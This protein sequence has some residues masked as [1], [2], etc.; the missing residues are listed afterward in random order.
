MK[1]IFRVIL[2]LLIVQASLASLGQETFEFSLQDAINYAMQNNYE[3]IYSEKNI[4]AAK[5]QMKE[6]TAFGLPQIDGSLDYAD[7]IQNPTSVIPGDFFGAPGED[8][9]IQ[10]GTKYSVNA[11]LYASQLL[12]SGKYIVGLKTA[13]IFM[14]KASIDFFKDK[15]AVTQQVAD[16]Y[17]N[18]LATEEQL[19]VVDTTLKVTRKIADETK[20]TYEVGFAEDLDVDQLDLLVSDLEASRVYLENQLSIA[21]A[22]L[23]FFLGLDNEDTVVLKDEMFNLIEKRKDSEI[24]S[25]IFNVNENV[26]YISLEKTK[27]IRLMQVKLEKTAYQPTLAASINLQ[28]NAQRNS[29]DFFSPDGKWY[30]SSAFGVNLIVPIWSSGERRAKVKQAQIAFEQIN[31]QQDQLKVSLNLQYQTALN[32]YFNAFTVYQ[33]RDKSRKVAAKIFQTTSIKFT[34][35]MAGS[36]DILNTQNQFLE[37]ERAFIEAGRMLLQAGQE[38]ERLMTK[39]INP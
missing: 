24:V 12:Y 23:K 39:A 10:F 2:T 8:V 14:E 16:S 19:R 25:Q 4:E 32:E 34:E 35:G 11:G 37:S 31:V 36:L 13:K 27:E 22:Y 9:E 20:L 3:V 5:Q 29:W 7:N 38:L 30:A 15:V 6:A 21:H 17:Y 18:V 33:N 1:F 26:D 28:T